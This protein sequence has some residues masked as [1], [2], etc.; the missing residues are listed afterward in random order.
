MRAVGLH[1]DVVVVTSRFWQTTCTL[2]RSGAEAFCIDSPV[3][4]DELELLPAIAEQSGFAVV[5]ALVTHVDWD[6]L[7]ALRL[8]GL[9]AQ[10]GGAR[11]RHSLRRRR[12]GVAREQVIPVDVR[13]Q[14]ADDRE[15][16]LL[17]D[18]RQ[19]LELVG[20]DRRVDA[21]RLRPAAHQRAVGLPDA[22]HRDHD[23]GVQTDC[24]HAAPSS[25]AASRSVLTSAVGFF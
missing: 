2:V 3:L 1:P 10:P 11:L 25:L 19:Q 12:E 7:L 5:G 9:V 6:H 24:L 23:V 16:G 8:A 17:G 20:K 18:R 22:R 14:R 13:D 21:E 15:P 4:P